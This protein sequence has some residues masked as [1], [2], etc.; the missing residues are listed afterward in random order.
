MIL[1]AIKARATLILSTIALA[2]AFAGGFELQGVI[3]DGEIAAINLAHQTAIATATQEKLTAVTKA[4]AAEQK[5]T[6]YI[7]DLTAKYVEDRQHENAV[8][9]R[10]IADLAAGNER[11]RVAVE[12]A[13]NNAGVP[14]LATAAAGGDGQAYQV[15]ARPVAA[16]LAGRYADYNE[17]VDQLTLCQGVVE[18]D[19]RTI[20]L[21]PVTP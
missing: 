8:T 10:R 5:A 11:L 12:I 19:R 20:N 6:Q 17:L 1:D 15:I 18:T 9:Q 4:R 21:A 14:S 16:R 7:A 13:T 3:K 2:I